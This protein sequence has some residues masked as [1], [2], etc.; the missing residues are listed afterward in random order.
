[1]SFFYGLK[2][3]I[4]AVFSVAILLAA[5]VACLAADEPTEP[6]LEFAFEEIVTLSAPMSVGPTATGKRNIV[7]ITGG[8]FAGPGIEGTIVPGGWDWQLMRSDGCIEIEA[9][10]ML[11]TSD[12]VIINVL[13]KG[14]IC[15]SDTGEMAPARTHPVF[16]APVGKYDW[17]NK[18]TFIG[19]LERAGDEHKMAVKIRFYKVL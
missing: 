15:K 11:K 7:P 13:N 6:Y 12:E 14:T 9:D 5:S 8:T 4:G 3:C 2:K 16:V 18:T 1:M 17:L 10:Y 19:T